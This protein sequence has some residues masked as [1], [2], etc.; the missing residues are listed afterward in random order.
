MYEN[1]LLPS[2]F[3]RLVV[4]VSCLSASVFCPL[5]GKDADWVHSLDTFLSEHCFE[6][7]DENSAKGG[8]NLFD[9]GTDL[10]DPEL[11]RKWVL[12]Y[13]RVALGEMPPKKKKRPSEKDQ[14]AFLQNLDRALSASD[15]ARK[16]VVLRRLNRLEYENTLRDLFA[17]PHLSVR[18]HV[19]GGCPGARIRHDRGSPRTIDRAN[20]G[21]PGGGRPSSRSGDRSAPSTRYPDFDL[22]FETFVG[23]SPGETV[24]RTSRGS[25]P[26]QLQVF[27]IDLSRFQDRTA[28]SL[29][30]SP[31]GPAPSSRRNQ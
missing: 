12:A 24:P 3:A 30:V 23:T 11:M 4:L 6:C 8:L 13:D 10:T 2:S 22:Q 28:R 26:L 1:A 5:S 19:A 17:L 27:P 20:D 29:S 18:G 21:L 7:H 14:S 15:M 16:E 9:L 25:R 31:S